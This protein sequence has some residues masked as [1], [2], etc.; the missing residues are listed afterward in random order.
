MNSLY[1]NFGVCPIIAPL[2]L[3][4]YPPPPPPPP[5]YG[6]GYLPTKLGGYNG[7]DHKFQI[8][9]SLEIKKEFFFRMLSFT[10]VFFR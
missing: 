1:I 2:P 10:H 5:H 8:L 9:C 3:K 7:K 4:L 6:I